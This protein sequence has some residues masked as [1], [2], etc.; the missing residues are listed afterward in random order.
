MDPSNTQRELL[1]KMPILRLPQDV[2][3]S[4]K[5]NITH[6]IRDQIPYQLCHVFGGAPFMCRLV[7][8]ALTEISNVLKDPF[9]HLLN[10]ARSQSFDVD[11]ALESMLLLVNGRHRHVH[12]AEEFLEGSVNPRLLYV[13]IDAINI[14]QCHIRVDRNPAWSKSNKFPCLLSQSKASEATSMCTCHSDDEA[15][16]N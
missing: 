6:D 2:P 13:G 3:V 4:T 15:R 1:N 8:E 5:G 16:K 12:I 11:S 10:R 9:L 14:T 7:N